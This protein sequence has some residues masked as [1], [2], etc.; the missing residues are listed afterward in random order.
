[1]RLSKINIMRYTK[2]STEAELIFF[3]LLATSEE[4]LKKFK[5]TYEMYFELRQ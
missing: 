4:S 2:Q 1:M 5:G 3:F